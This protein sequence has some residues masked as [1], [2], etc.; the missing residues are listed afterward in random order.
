LDGTKVRKKDIVL[1]YAKKLT[2]YAVI[3]RIFEAGEKFSLP[4]NPGIQIYIPPYVPVKIG[5]SAE[6]YDLKPLFASSR[7]RVHYINMESESKK[8]HRSLRPRQFFDFMVSGEEIATI[9]SPENEITE[10]IK[11]PGPGYLVGFQV[12]N[13]TEVEPGDIIMLFAQKHGQ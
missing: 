9:Y 7:G 11:S 10:T 6:I 2:R 13:N 3:P 8:E 1:I 4:R 12:L 5:H